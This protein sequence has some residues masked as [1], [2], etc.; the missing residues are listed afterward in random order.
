MSATA[1]PIVSEFATN[2]DAE[3]HDRWFRAKVTASLGDGQP[4]I[5]HDQVMAEMEAIIEEA[6]RKRIKSA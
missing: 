5:P 6:E 1:S 3:R 2:E 4:C